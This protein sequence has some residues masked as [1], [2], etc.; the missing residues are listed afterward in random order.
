MRIIIT[1]QRNQWTERESIHAFGN[2]KD[3]KEFL[4][5][6]MNDALEN[7]K[8]DTGNDRTGMNRAETDQTLLAFEQC[9]KE[10]DEL[11][12]DW[13]NESD[14]LEIPYGDDVLFYD[15]TV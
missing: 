6:E 11:N 9:Q 1:I 15:R 3:L 5:D 8:R 4:K 10:I 13:T 14:V 2:E 7:F 12:F